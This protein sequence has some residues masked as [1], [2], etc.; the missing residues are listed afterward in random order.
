[1]ISILVI[2]ACFV[3]AI[4]VNIKNGD[5]LFAKKRTYGRHAKH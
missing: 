4:L 5:K 3:I 1:M 2:I